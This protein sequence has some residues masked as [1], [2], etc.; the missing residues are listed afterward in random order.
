MSTLELDSRR[1]SSH[2]QERGHLVALYR[3]KA[4]WNGPLPSGQAVADRYFA[5]PVHR[6]R[7]A[8]HYLAGKLQF[9]R[10]AEMAFLHGPRAR[11]QME[12]IVHNYLYL[13]RRWS[14][15]TLI[16]LRNAEEL[17]LFY[18]AMIA[19]ESQIQLPKGRL[20]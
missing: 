2:G 1:P 10:S 11:I 9:R 8:R 7:S 12:C 19:Y 5:D 15:D 3:E 13:G 18:N 14:T 4:N 17:E 6:L 16:K 20:L